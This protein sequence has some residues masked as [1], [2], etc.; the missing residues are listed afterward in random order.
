ML[1]VCTA[2]GGPEPSR[3]LFS[4]GYAEAVLALRRSLSCVCDRR[5]AV[6]IWK[7]V[8]LSWMTLLTL[9]FGSAGATA[10][11]DVSQ[12]HHVWG[13]DLAVASAVEVNAL[14]SP[15]E[16]R[17]KRCFATTATSDVPHAARGAK[18]P[19]NRGTSRPQSPNQ[20][21]SIYEQMDPATGKVRSMTKTEDRSRARILITRTVE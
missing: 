11:S 13:I 19:T 1:F 7:R 15:E 8:I 20:P 10:G 12:K 2:R 16:H 4:A 17:G 14:A 21:N 3:G 9:L 5:L 18:T 6:M